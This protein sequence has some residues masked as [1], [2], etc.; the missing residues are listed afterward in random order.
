[1]KK[2]K[3]LW[4]IYTQWNNKEQQKSAYHYVDGTRGC[5]VKS[6]RRES[7]KE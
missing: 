2:Q 5:R 6:V 3:K 1:M 7:N 4:C